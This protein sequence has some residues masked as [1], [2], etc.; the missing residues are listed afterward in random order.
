M[1]V[2]DGCRSSLMVRSD[3][4][5]ANASVFPT[6]QMLDG[7]ISGNN[8]ACGG[9]EISKEEEQANP[10]QD[11]SPGTSLAVVGKVTDVS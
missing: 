8:S 2:G 10:S 3:R 5:I 9:S 4:L 1:L 11:E 6:E 7:T